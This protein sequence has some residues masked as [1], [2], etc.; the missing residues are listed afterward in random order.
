MYFWLKFSLK[1]VFFYLFKPFFWKIFWILL[2]FVQFKTIRTK[3]GGLNEI[4]FHHKFIFLIAKLIVD[5]LKTDTCAG[6]YARRQFA[7]QTS[8]SDVDHTPPCLTHHSGVKNSSCFSL[9]YV[10]YQ[11]VCSIPNLSSVSHHRGHSI[12]YRVNHLYHDVMLGCL[13]I[14]F[15]KKSC[16]LQRRDIRRCWWFDPT[17]LAALK[18]RFFKV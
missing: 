18:M 3:F 9:Q 10:L 12:F 17:C 6:T 1:N 5:S 14:D 16:S 2:K 13:T 11:T 15:T 7:F 4:S 8:S